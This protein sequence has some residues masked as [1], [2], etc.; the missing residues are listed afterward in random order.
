MGAGRGRGWLAAL[1][2]AL[3]LLAAG[4]RGG[5]SAAAPNMSLQMSNGTASVTG[6]GVSRT[7]GTQLAVSVGYRVVVDP[8]GLAV[9]QVSPGRTFQLQEGEALITAPD[10]IQLVRG[11]LLAQL[12]RH[13]EV[14]APGLVIASDAGTLRVD[15]GPSAR[16][17]VYAGSASV[18]SPATTLPVT[19]YEQVVDA[20]GTLPRAPGPLQIPAGGDVWDHQFLQGAIDLD[21]RLANFATGLEAQLGNA[22]G[23]AFF[24]IVIPASADTPDVT[25]YLDRRRSDV[26]TGWV[27]A[28]EAAAKQHASVAQTFTAVMTLWEAGESWGLLAMQLGVTA[29]EVFAGLLNAIRE[30]GISVT[31]PVPHLPQAPPVISRPSAK[32]TT[33]T[34]PTASP[35]APPVVAAPAPSPSPTSLLSGLLNPV[36]ALLNEVLNLLLPGLAPTP[37]PTPTH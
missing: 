22:S 16:V 37:T 3:A 33:G 32:P 24:K 6:G 1:G 21:N 15:S 34:R 28:S 36:T 12:T 23:I 5:G 31:S 19:A 13:A 26:L 25:P 9:L 27:I 35:A 11:S 2:L 14:E 10:R 17:G 7:V 18:R 29:D 8:G 4:C 30:V 20:A